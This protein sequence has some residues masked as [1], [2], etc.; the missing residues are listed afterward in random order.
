MTPMNT[1]WRKYLDP[2]IY[3]WIVGNKINTENGIP[4]SFDDFKFLLMPLM[5][6]SPKQVYIKA[7]QV[8]MTVTTFLKVVFFA[9]KYSADAIYTLPT[10]TDVK[11][12]V[13]DKFNRIIS[14]NKTIQKLTEDKDSIE[15]KIISNDRGGQSMIKFRGTLQEKDA[16][17]V[18]SDLNVHDE[19]D[20]SN[21]EVVD[22]YISRLQASTL[23][24]PERGN[25]E[26][27]FSHPSY[28]GVGVDEKW[29]ISDQKHWIIK[30]SH[31]NKKQ[32]LSWPDSFD[33]EKKIYVCKYCN[34]EIYDDDRRKGTWMPRKGREDAKKYPYSGYWMPLMINPRKSAE[35]IIDLYETKDGEFFTTKV[36]GLPY[37]ES[38]KIVSK[39][40]I[41]QNVTEE[42]NKLETRTVIGVDTG[43]TTYGVVGNRKG[44]FFYW[45]EK[46]YDTF[47]ELMNK[48]PD[49][50]AVFDAQGDLQKPRE[51][52]EKYKGRIYFAYYAEDR[53]TDEIVQFSKNENT[54]KIQRNK[55]I[56]FLITE[57]TFGNRMP[58][59]GTKTDWK[60]F[61][62]HWTNIYKEE[63]ENRLNVKVGRWQRNG[64]DHWVHA[65]VYFRA[66]L[67]RFGQ[68]PG[69]F[70][71]G[72]AE[73][74]FKI[75][76][77]Q[78]EQGN[79][80]IGAFL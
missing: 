53:K 21:M 43:L 34:G 38:D 49:A 78:D 71:G 60:E 42:I 41:L 36:L 51:L 30:C 16:I 31:C 11:N 12:I 24:D 19:L 25:Y 74:Q 64:A 2:E 39:E 77:I 37:R 80:F 7:A 44:K 66:G 68:E 10:K 69:G 13:S 15:Q 46:G 17:S 59:M 61:A 26:W 56:D 62:T 4:Y 58:L 75:K 27:Y 20:A 50:I 48:Y 18:S 63:Q 14:M 72:T 70:I 55:M 79:N 33:M 8:G 47:E 65:D 52:A 29:Q 9:K 32:F 76:Q 1:M 22:Q 57:Y 67:T 23:V 73:P 28:P 45:S 3:K 54:L 35:Y 40:V 6:M 5:D